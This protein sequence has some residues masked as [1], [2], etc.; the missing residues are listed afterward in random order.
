MAKDKKARALSAVPVDAAQLTPAAITPDTITPDLDAELEALLD[1][2]SDAEFGESEAQVASAEPRAVLKEWSAQDFANIYTRFR[3][4]LERHARRFLRNPSQ[5]DEVVQDAFLYLMVTLPELDS[6]VGV[7]RFL[8]WKTRLLCLDVIRAS[9]RAQISNIDAHAEFESNDPE[10]GTNLEQ[11]ED[12]AI[13]RL[14]LSKLN[15]RH[16]EVLLA[17]M[18][19]EKSTREIAAQVGLSENATLQLIFRARSAFK[20]ALLG[21]NFETAG[22]SVSAILS[23]AARKAAADAKKVGAQAMVFVLFLML[24]VGGFVSFSNRNTDAT[25]VAEGNAPAS[26]TSEPVASAPIEAPN[27]K[28]A[29]DEAPA[30]TTESAPAKTSAPVIQ[31][32]VNTPSQAPAASPSPS[33]SPFS[34][35][36]L[37]TIYDSSK[38][39]VFFARTS[40]STEDFGVDAAQGYLVNASQGISAEFVFEAD[41]A[42]PFKNVVVAYI[43]D[44]V[45]YF[46]YPTVTDVV[47]GVDQF[48]IQHVVYFGKAKYFADAN[49][50]VYTDDK[51]S[52]ST[53]RIELVIKKDRSG[54]QSTNLDLLRAE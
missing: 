21:D 42:V 43:I 16:R 5:V 37:A 28:T 24:A 40:Q 19:E 47:V 7:L 52:N 10:M 50:K 9:G 35:N 39:E 30:E 8:K 46:S 53:V 31:T 13:V 17:S 54:V 23:V 2:E 3:P 26:E 36:A 6:E 41:A 51:L 38:S 33:S 11:A 34:T 18:Y 12:A 20:K 4:H 15:P 22:M 44:G 49:R 25:T 29:T 45:P 14:A 1:E 27:A 48:G 32:V